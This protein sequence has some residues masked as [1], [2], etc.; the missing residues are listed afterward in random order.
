MTKLELV[1]HAV[2]AIV[3]IVIYGWLTHD[4][5]DGNPLLGLLGG[6]GL[7]ALISSASAAKA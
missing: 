6:Q 3:I 5:I 1:L 4:G 2:T 7:G